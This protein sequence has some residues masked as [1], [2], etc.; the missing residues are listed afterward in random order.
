[1]NRDARRFVEHDYIAIFKD[2]GR[3]DEF[4]K[5][6]RRRLR[7]CRGSALERWKADSV[8]L[9]DPMFRSRSASIYAYLPSAQ[10]PIDET[11]GNVFHMSGEEVVDALTGIAARGFQVRNFGGLFTDS[12]TFVRLHDTHT[13]SDITAHEPRRIR[14]QGESCAEMDAKVARFADPSLKC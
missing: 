14:K 13:S 4:T 10:N 7:R 3:S 11:A 6:F 8:T 9:S 1:M 2:H 5:R 12:A